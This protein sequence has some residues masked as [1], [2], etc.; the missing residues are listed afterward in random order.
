MKRVLLI[1]GSSLTVIFLVLFFAMRIWCGQG[2]KERIGIAKQ[3]QKKSLNRT[4][5]GHVET[6]SSQHNL[7]KYPDR[8]LPGSSQAHILF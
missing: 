4:G 5:L 6:S 7:R 2:I 8:L 3:Q 1:I